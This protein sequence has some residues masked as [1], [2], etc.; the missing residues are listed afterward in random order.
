MLQGCY[1][2]GEM[3]L[4]PGWREILGNTGEIWEI[5]GN[6]KFQIMDF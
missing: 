6:A 3:G 1:I 5:P 2:S 4:F